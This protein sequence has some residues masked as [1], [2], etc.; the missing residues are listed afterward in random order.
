[1]NDVSRHSQNPGDIVNELGFDY[2][3]GSDHY[4]LGCLRSL[5]DVFSAV[6]HEE[7]LSKRENFSNATA[8]ECFKVQHNGSQ[9]LMLDE[10]SLD[11]KLDAISKGSAAGTS[12]TRVLLVF[13]VPL[14][15][16]KSMSFGTKISMTQ[17]SAEKLFF[18]LELHPLL[19][20]NML[21]RPA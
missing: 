12:H 14:T 15:P 7:H 10:A 1:M 16:T 4:P 11:R 19:I 3:L 20:L 8:V 21:R 2:N 17:E 5:Q 18:V 13:V 9:W 6:Q